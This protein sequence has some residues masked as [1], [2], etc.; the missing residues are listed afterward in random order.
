[1]PLPKACMPWPTSQWGQT[2]QAI[3]QNIKWPSVGLQV[4]EVCSDKDS[5]YLDEHGRYWVK[6]IFDHTSSTQTN[7]S[8][9]LRMLQPSIS[10]HPERQMGYTG[11]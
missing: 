9:T 10:Q 1:M 6:P 5:V 3:K 4:G 11:R 7:K 8:H 2:P